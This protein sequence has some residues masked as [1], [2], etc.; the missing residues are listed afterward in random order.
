MNPEEEKRMDP[1]INN[2]NNMKHGKAMSE[3]LIVW[4]GVK[5]KCVTKMFSPLVLVFFFG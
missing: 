5:Q 1:N 3:I 4:N 2:N